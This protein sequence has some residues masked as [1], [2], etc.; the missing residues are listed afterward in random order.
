MPT[1]YPISVHYCRFCGEHHHKDESGFFSVNLDQWFCNITCYYQARLSMGELGI[2]N[3]GLSRELLR[4]R[5]TVYVPDDIKKR[6]DRFR[7]HTQNG[8]FKVI[9]RTHAR[10]DVV[11]DQD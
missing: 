9:R 6:K 7:K 5:E 4:L 11:Q 1:S 8:H 3:N 2:K 10:E